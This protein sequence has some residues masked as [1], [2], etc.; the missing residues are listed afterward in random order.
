MRKRENLKMKLPK[1]YNLQEQLL[2][3]QN[4]VRDKYKFL[5]KI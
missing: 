5:E 4:K 3:I 2:L 1:N